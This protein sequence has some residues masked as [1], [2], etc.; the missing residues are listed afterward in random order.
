MDCFWIKSIMNLQII[1]KLLIG[2]MN[3]RMNFG[4]NYLK[5]IIGEKRLQKKIVRN[6]QPSKKE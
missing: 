3:W 4:I 1:N 2:I 5:N 6:L